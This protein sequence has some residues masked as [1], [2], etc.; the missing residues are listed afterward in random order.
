MEASVSGLFVI[1]LV[2]A[3]IVHRLHVLWTEKK[4]RDLERIERSVEAL[5][6]EA[7][8]Q[9]AAL[10]MLQWTELD[11]IE[12]GQLDPDH[13]HLDWDVHGNLIKVPST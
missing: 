12:N 11:L 1:V 7:D 3:Y 4:K 6:D 10:C 2:F 13:E 5:L 8:R 9:D